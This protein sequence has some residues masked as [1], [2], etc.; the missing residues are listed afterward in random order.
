MNKEFDAVHTVRK[1]REEIYEQTKDMSAAE[2]IEFFQ[3][4]SSSTKQKLAQV[5][6]RRT[7]EA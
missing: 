1:I 2:L 3:T 4:R 7:P 6:D 5:K